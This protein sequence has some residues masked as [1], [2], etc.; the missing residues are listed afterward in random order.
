MALL[1]LNR[2]NVKID[3][4]KKDFTANSLLYEPAGSAFSSSV[5]PAENIQEFCASVSPNS[6][7]PFTPRT[8]TG[9]PETEQAHGY[10]GWYL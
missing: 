5:L 1:L 9:N 6:W 3:V 8:K 4:N 7:S 10:T 2:S